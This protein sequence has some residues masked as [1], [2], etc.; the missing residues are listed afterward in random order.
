MS[1][2]SITPRWLTQEQACQYLGGC[3][4]RHIQAMQQAGKIPVSYALG[5]RSPRYDRIALDRW[6]QGEHTPDAP[7][8]SRGVRL[9]VG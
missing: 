2:L 7:T 6:M 4:P 1:E 5:V 3:S 9:A 8:E